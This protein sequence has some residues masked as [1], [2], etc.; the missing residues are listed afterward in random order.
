[1]N[2][3]YDIPYRDNTRPPISV[4]ELRSIRKKLKEEGKKNIDEDLIFGAYQRMREIEENAI[5]DTRKTRREK[6][7][8]RI[9]GKAKE[10]WPKRKEEKQEEAPN[11]PKQKIVP[12]EEMEEL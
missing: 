7:R 4:W 3:Y 10:S 8:R 6:Q 2:R 1:M 11:V 12:F 5:K 9:H